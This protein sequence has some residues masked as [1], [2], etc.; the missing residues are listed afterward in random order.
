MPGSPLRLAPT[1]G[2]G[3]LVFTGVRLAA[4]GVFI[5][6]AGLG[7]SVLGPISVRASPFPPIFARPDLD[8]CPPLV[9]LVASLG[10]VRPP[11]CRRRRRMIAR[12]P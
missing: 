6:F 8:A 12:Q 3:P 10:R 4:G 1:A 5:E 2:I 9:R 11:A 7:A